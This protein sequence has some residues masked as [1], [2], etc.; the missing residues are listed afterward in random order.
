MDPRIHLVGATVGLFLASSTV[1]AG[2]TWRELLPQ[3]GV[4][5]PRRGVA[6]IHDAAHNRL[7]FQGAE[8]ADV[9][10]LPDVWV[11][12][13]AHNT[14]SQLSDSRPDARC[15]HTFLVDSERGRGL[16]FGGF[17]R[18]DK[19]W[20]WDVVASIWRDITPAVGPPPRCLHTSVIC[21]SRGEMVVY[22]GLQ[23]GFTPDLADTWSYDLA[24]DSW[25]LL[26]EN[27]RP[28]TRYGHVAA[29]D[30]S[31]DRMIIFGGFQRNG[32]SGRL[33][34][35]G[36]LW[37]FDLAT[38]RWT[39]L[40]PSNSGPSPREFA[41][42][43]RMPDGSGMVL[44]GG[45][46]DVTGIMN[47]LWFLDFGDLRWTQL[48]PEG[49]LPPPRFRHTLILDATGERLW[50]AF[51]EGSS[52][53]HFSDVWTLDLKSMTDPSAAFQRGD[54]DADGARNISDAV[55]T[56]QFLFGGG[57]EPTCAK[58]AD[59]NDDGVL[60]LDDP[61]LLLDAL[62][63]GYSPPASPYDSCGSDPTEDELT[64]DSHPPCS[65]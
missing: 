23:G 33:E 19:L 22:G 35:V 1:S 13:L 48:E 4:P 64:C 56:L 26:V 53:T 40:S 65:R 36:D 28:G 59:V 30:E 60:K 8:T 25:T 15:H 47:D 50:V 11:F 10:F 52:G 61:V 5:S 34:D 58:S 9:R 38:R 18:T 24:G 37:A 7:V 51:G 41:R 39:E 55:L 45:R 32:A 6:G 16:L 63:L 17:P 42:G 43:T 27:S 46:S 29:L 57:P 3:G 12:D 54:V 31:R 62:F 20:S 44:F 2:P 49:S 21:S 14:W